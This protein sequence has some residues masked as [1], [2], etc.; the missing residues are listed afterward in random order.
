MAVLRGDSRA[1]AGKG[2]GRVLPKNNLQKVFLFYSDHGSVGSIGMPVGPPIYANELYTVLR[3]MADSNHFDEMLIYLE[4]CDAGS[5]FR[6]FDLGPKIMAATA[7]N[8]FESSYATYCP[9]QSHYTTRYDVPNATYIGACMG[10]LF[11]VSWMEDTDIA[12]RSEVLVQEQLNRVRFRT[13]TYNLYIYGSH[14]MEYGDKHGYITREVIGNYLSYFVAPPSWRTSDL[15]VF[16]SNDLQSPSPVDVRY[17]QHQADLLPLYHRALKNDEAAIK[18]LEIEMK[19]RRFVD[20]AIRTLVQDL[21]DRGRLENAVGVEKYVT[22]EVTPGEQ[23]VR[24]WGCLK[25]MVKNWEGYC[26]I[27]DEYARQ[28]TRALVNLCNA[29]IQPSEILPSLMNICPV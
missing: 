18:E 20:G 9:D 24:S 1:M 16:Y 2:S 13:S 17:D 25:D 8:A 12:N 29:G 21:M 10:D 14:V 28:Y 5:M 4:S 27:M 11:S 6:G 26:G 15:D 23:V 22:E 3:S 7:A 19:K